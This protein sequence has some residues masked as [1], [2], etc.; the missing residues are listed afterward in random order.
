M[1]LVAVAAFS[2]LINY[3]YYYRGEKKV[4]ATI[5]PKSVVEEKEEAKKEEPVVVSA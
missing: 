5:L 4:Q 2:L 1:V 3:C